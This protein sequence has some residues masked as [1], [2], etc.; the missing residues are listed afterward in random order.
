MPD[1]SI[2]YP[3]YPSPASEPIDHEENKSSYKTAFRDSHHMIRYHHDLLPQI[4]NI[5]FVN[6]ALGETVEE[7]LNLK[8]KKKKI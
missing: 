3:R 2:R 4:E 8:K 1:F 5:A 7:K 6:D